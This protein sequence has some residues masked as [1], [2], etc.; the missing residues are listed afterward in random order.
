MTFEFIFSSVAGCNNEDE[1]NKLIAYSKTFG[2]LC[3]NHITLL[4]K[5]PHGN[6][7]FKGEDLERLLVSGLYRKLAVQRCYEET[8]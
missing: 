1:I 6:I 2:V 3:R 5:R 7:S 8:I 4:E